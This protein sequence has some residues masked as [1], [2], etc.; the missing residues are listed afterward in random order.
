M[1]EQIIK[2]IVEIAFV[3]RY[4]TTLFLLIILSYTTYKVYQ[5]EGYQIRNAVA[6]FT[7]GCVIITVFYHVLHYEY[8]QRRFKHDIKAS[9][10]LLSFNTALEWQKE[11]L[12]NQCV[13]A[14]RFYRKYKEM[15]DDRSCRLFQAEIEKDENEKFL[16]ATHSVLN[17][18]E[19]ISLGV[20]Q[21]LID[22][23]FIKGFFRGIFVVYYNRYLPYIEYRRRFT[24]NVKIFEEFTNL[25]ERWMLKRR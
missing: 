9:K 17:F 7:G 20:K 5:L 21:G 19:S 14:R 8:T 13:L 3:I 6:V 10:D 11:F 22:D 1:K 4:W 18:L 16:L 23:D 24:S 25:A 15:L 12:T 2:R